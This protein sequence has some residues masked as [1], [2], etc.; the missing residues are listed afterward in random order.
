MARNSITVASG[1]D[2]CLP[3]TMPAQHHVPGLGGTG[4]ISSLF[5]GSGL[6][7]LPWRS[8]GP[9]RLTMRCLSWT[10]SS[11]LRRP[12]TNVQRVLTGADRTF[13]VARYG[14]GC[15]GGMGGVQRRGGRPRRRLT[16]WMTRCGRQF[17]L[18][19]RPASFSPELGSRHSFAVE[20]RL[21]AS[22]GGE[23]LGVEGRSGRFGQG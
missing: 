13:L 10:W 15:A 18:T 2:L 5:L 22:C 19:R 21:A 1:V 12:V 11:H 16:G 9:R 20:A 14:E 4:L 7:R 3:G 8:H 17:V 6:L 23:T